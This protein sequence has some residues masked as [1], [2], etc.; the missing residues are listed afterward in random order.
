MGKLSP[1]LRRALTSMRLSTAGLAPVSTK[2]LSACASTPLSFGSWTSSASGRPIAS[3]ARQPYAWVRLAA[4]PN[5][6]VKQGSI[7]ASTRGSTGV[8][9][10]ASR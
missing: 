9:E 2:R 4:F 10:W 3:S 7:A 5:S 1:V 6:S 8:V